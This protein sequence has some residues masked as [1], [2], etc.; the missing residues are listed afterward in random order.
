MS[1]ITSPGAT[2]TALVLLLTVHLA[3]NY[4]AVSCVAM[5]TLN[6]QRTN[7]VFS[8]FRETGEVLT[9]EQVAGR[10]RVLERSGVLR[11]GDSEIGSARVGVQFA[12]VVAS[13]AGRGETEGPKGGGV[14]PPRVRQKVHALAR[15]FRNEQYLLWPAPAGGSRGLPRIYIC[16]KAGARAKDQVKAWSHALSVA[17]A[18][19]Q[20]GEGAGGLE[21]DGEWY[22]EGMGLVQS[23]LGE[24]EGFA[25]MAG[26]L[27]A[28]GWDLD[29][30]CIETRSGYRCVVLEGSAEGKKGV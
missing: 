25:E 14:P 16:L 1:H 27:A 30:A 21:I 19:S 11:W 12:T 20:R 8:R 7:I 2:W 5:R 17:K 18:I 22:G 28:T 23:T 15:V 10:E 24:L 4:K 29:T 26:R 6:R 9:P 3:T 13:L